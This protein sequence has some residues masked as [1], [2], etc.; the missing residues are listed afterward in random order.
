LSFFEIIFKISLVVIL[1]SI[2]GIERGMRHKGAGLRTHL[3]VGV[4]SALIVLTSL[5]LLEI[6]KSETVVDPTR[7]IAGIITGIGFLCAGTIIRGEDNISGLTTAATL[8]I[9]SCIGIAV[10]SGQ[11]AAAII[12]SI[13]VIIILLKARYIEK[14]L[15]NKFKKISSG[16]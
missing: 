7:M 1:S 4:G 10:G 16:G 15:E 5:H 8:W 13:F 12:V 9:V 3:L 14:W 6:Y 11:Y 2:I